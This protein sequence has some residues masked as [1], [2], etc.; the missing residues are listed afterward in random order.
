M[1]KF[2][3]IS[4]TILTFKLIHWGLTAV[5]PKLDKIKQ[6]EREKLCKLLYMLAAYLFLVCSSFSTLQRGMSG[7]Y[8][9]FSGRGQFETTPE[10]EVFLFVPLLI[11]FSLTYLY[12]FFYSNRYQIE[13]LSSFTLLD[14]S[15]SHFMWEP[16]HSFIKI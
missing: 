11:G 1:I 15:P 10:F 9:N 12:D 5:Y 4:R 13:R 3:K 2:L 8:I 16:K 6:Q 7:C 14:Y